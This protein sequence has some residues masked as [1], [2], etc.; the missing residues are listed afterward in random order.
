MMDCGLW[1]RIYRKMGKK[2]GVSYDVIIQNYRDG[3]FLFFIFYIFNPCKIVF[4]SGG[5]FFLFVGR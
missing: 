3:L 5:G 4:Y 2:K 1:A